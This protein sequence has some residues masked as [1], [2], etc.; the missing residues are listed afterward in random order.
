MDN[1]IALTTQ[2]SSH[3]SIRVNTRVLVVDDDAAYLKIVEAMLRELQYEVVAVKCASEALAILWKRIVEFSIILTDLHIPEMDGIALLERVEVEF[4]IPVVI[5]SANDNK[6][7]KSR[8]LESG[9]AFYVTKPLTASDL[10]NLWQKRLSVHPLSMKAIGDK[11][12]GKNLPQRS[13]KTK[14]EIKR[15]ILHK[16]SHR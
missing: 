10:R 13:T 15:T 6:D 16:R 9:T 7:V 11:N 5:M 14:G 2:S 8:C 4:K 12:Q 1:Q 3:K